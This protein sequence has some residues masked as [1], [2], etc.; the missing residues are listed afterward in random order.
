MILTC[1]TDSAGTASATD[2]AANLTAAATGCVQQS[3]RAED[4]R[5]V[6]VVLLLWLLLLI[7]LLWV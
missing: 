3:V 7:L 4:Q 2:A 5:V 1:L 6:R